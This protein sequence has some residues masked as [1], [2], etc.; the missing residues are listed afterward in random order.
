MQEEKV[1]IEGEKSAQI[2]VVA[3]K[4]V[5]Q[6]WSKLWLWSTNKLYLILVSYFLVIMFILCYWFD[7]KAGMTFTGYFY[8]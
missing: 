2:S 4:I 6:G 8:F 7:Q 3:K 5:M 1:D